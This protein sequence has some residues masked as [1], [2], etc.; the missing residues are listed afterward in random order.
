MAK[1][2]APRV[3]GG[4]TS[5]AILMDTKENPQMSTQMMIARRALFR[6]FIGLPVSNIEHIDGFFHG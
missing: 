2:R 5:T 4:S 1:R 6:S 3:M